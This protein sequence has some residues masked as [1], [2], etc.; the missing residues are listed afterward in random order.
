VIISILP[1]SVEYVILLHDILNSIN[2]RKMHIDVCDNSTISNKEVSFFCENKENISLCS[3][4]QSHGYN[5]PNNLELNFEKLLINDKNSSSKKE[6]KQEEL[7][8]LKK[9]HKN[10]WLLFSKFEENL[11][12]Y[13]LAYEY[14]QKGLSFK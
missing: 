6:N 1:I 10:L 9:G 11:G 14:S 7:V 5:L 3:N 13:E 4:K 12:N 8:L 2:P